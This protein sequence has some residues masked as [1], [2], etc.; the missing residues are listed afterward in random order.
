[1]IRL[2]FKLS[3]F[4]GHPFPHGL[5]GHHQGRHLVHGLQMRLIAY[6]EHVLAVFLAHLSYLLKGLGVKLK[7]TSAAKFSAIHR[8]HLCGVCFYWL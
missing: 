4:G 8:L 6:L 1:M 2:R 7:V 3:L 5:L